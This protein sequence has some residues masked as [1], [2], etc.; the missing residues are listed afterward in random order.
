MRNLIK[1]IFRRKKEIKITFCGMTKD[2]T[3]ILQKYFIVDPKT[4]DLETRRAIGISVDDGQGIYCYPDK[5][6]FK[7]IWRN[8]NA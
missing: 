2:E 1:S 6:K 4:G 5:V 7:M 3:K 8:D